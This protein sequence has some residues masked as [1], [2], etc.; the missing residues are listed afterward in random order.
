MCLFAVSEIKISRSRIRNGRILRTFGNR[1]FTEQ[2]GDVIA[3]G[4]R[5]GVQCYCANCM[6]VWLF[7][8]ENYSRAGCSVL[9]RLHRFAETHL[10]TVIIRFRVFWV[11]TLVL[12]RLRTFRRGNSCCHSRLFNCVH[13]ASGDD[14]VHVI[15]VIRGLDG[16]KCVMENEKIYLF[17]I[18]AEKYQCFDIDQ[19]EPS[20]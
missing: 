15:R 17:N 2:N 5:P 12:C 8:V 19:V 20:R 7:T 14:R 18:S 10:S 6:Y 11:R 16:E 13:F 1:M 3:R 9:A 4:H